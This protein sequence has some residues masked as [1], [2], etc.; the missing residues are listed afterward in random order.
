MK[1]H[2]P[3][4][5]FYFGSTPAVILAEYSLIKETFKNDSLA[6]RPDLTP[7]NSPG[8]HHSSN[9]ISFVEYLRKKLLKLHPNNNKQLSMLNTFT[10]KEKVFLN[11]HVTYRKLKNS[12]IFTTFNMNGFISGQNE[13]VF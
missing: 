1:K 10:L 13:H 2:G 3:I 11:I 7:G 8:I 9:G 6:A 5:G 12:A 4:F